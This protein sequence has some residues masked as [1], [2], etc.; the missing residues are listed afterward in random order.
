M[1]N[2]SIVQS[3][4]PYYIEDKYY[5]VFKDRMSEN[6]R[7]LF[8][9]KEYITV[10]ISWA[11]KRLSKMIRCYR[12]MKERT[13]NLFDNHKINADNI[14]TA[15]KY[16]NRVRHYNSRRQSLESIGD[17]IN[18][19]NSRIISKGTANKIPQEKRLSYF[20]TIYSLLETQS[21]NM[22][23]VRKSFDFSSIED[24]NNFSDIE[25]KLESPKDKGIITAENESHITPRFI[26]VHLEKEI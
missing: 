15:V 23:N 16:Y 21:G 19:I 14:Q 7:I 3:L 1:K 18:E 12:Q 2:S 25:N 20:S 4:N 24:K 10:N 13:L 6:L 8:P 26:K 22:E 5:S 17:S 9:G 11:A